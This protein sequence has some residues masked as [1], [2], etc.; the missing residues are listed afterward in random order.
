[1]IDV[2]GV[3]YKLNNS[4]STDP[5]G[6]S[7]GIVESKRYEGIKDGRNYFHIKF[8]NNN[9]WGPITHR[10]VLIDRTSP[11]EFQIIIDNKGDATNPSPYVNFPVIDEASGVEKYALI[12]DG[13]TNDVTESELKKTPYEFYKLKPGQHTFE[14]IAFDYAGNNASTSKTFLV[15]ALKA[16]VIT[17]MS[18]ILIKGDELVIQGTSFYPNANI[19][20]YILKDTDNDDEEAVEIEVKTD[21]D[22]NWTYFRQNDLGKGT[23]RVWA[24]VIDD[25]GAESY[26]SLKKTLTVKSPSVICAYGF[27]IILFLILVIIGLI[28]SIIYIKRM[29]KRQKGRAM[30]ESRELEK[31]LGEIFTALKEEVNELME[32]ADKKSGIS[33]SELRVKDKITEALDISQEFIGKEIKD[34]KKE[35]E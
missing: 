34:V 14:V 10:E 23:Y 12:L 26:D 19:K 35:I 16:P 5:G 15:E 30:R 8:Q 7:Q 24:K 4:S 2:S 17:E 29:H 32:F 33:E 6:V 13:V 31:R 28:A 18:K 21:S 1:M 27:W 3:S 22:G 9:G 11:L 20:I 25:R